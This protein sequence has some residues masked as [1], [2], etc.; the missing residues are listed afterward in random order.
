MPFVPSSVLA[1]T[2]KALVT[3]SDALV[4]SSFSL[5]VASCHGVVPFSR[6][7]S[8]R[9]TM[10]SQLGWPRVVHPHVFVALCISMGN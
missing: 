8:G 10:E 5:L 3:S 9:L 2:S 6:M 7:V 4:P 1:P